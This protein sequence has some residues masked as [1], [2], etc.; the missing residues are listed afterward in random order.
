MPTQPIITPTIIGL[1]VLVF[2]GIC[3]DIWWNDGS[4]VNYLTG[5][6]PAFP[7]QQGGFLLPGS[8]WWPPLDHPADSGGGW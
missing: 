6:G 1:N 7:G 5:S 8:L 3:V 2:L 4:V